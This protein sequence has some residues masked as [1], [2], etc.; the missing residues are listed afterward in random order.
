MYEI[1][2]YYEQMYEF[3]NNS[4]LYNFRFK[5]S[6]IPMW[7]Y[8]RS[9]FIRDVIDQTLYTQITQIEHIKANTKFIRKSFMSKYITKNPFFS[10]RKDILFAFWGYSELKKYDNGMVYEALIM[11]FLQMFS[12]KTSVLMHGN[13]SNEYEL[14]CSYPEWKMDD[15]FIDILNCIHNIKK[16]NI[17]NEDKKNI[18]DLVKF[19]DN[20]CPI[21]MNNCIKKKICSMLE[22][23]AHNNKFM[24][25]IC[26]LYL[27]VAKPKVVVICCGSYPGLLR[28]SLILACKN[29]SIVTAELQ[30]GLSARCHA[31]YQYGNYI[32]N[33][34]EC[35]RILPDY[36]LTFGEYWHNHV[37]IPQKCKVVGYAKPIVKDSVPVNQKILFCADLDF[38]RYLHFIDKIISHL[39]KSTE[40]YFRLHPIY[41]TKKQKEQFKK[42]LKYPNFFFA[43]DKDLSFYMK[44]CRYVIIDGST[45]C[46]EALFM[47]R[48]VFAF[49]SRQNT[50]VG[51]N[52]LPYVHLFNSSD[53]FL[54]LWNKRDMFISEYH[55]EFFNLEYKKNYIEFV[56][57]CGVKIKGVYKG[58]VR[59]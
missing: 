33:N 28:T 32:L 43:N 14:N 35:S 24:V 3:E 2:E 26:E 39:D 12:D 34:Y 40:I 19:L 18:K 37:N 51:I 58:C 54:K 48:I 15:I 27:Q 8:I 1:K 29:K 7:M 4:Q 42:Y 36:Y 23:F 6:G 10:Q 17:S 59:K 5:D 45:V 53:D 55:D 22:D 11:P 16:Q 52:K 9:L 21:K 49:E 38:D 57:E 30:H 44:E 56:K 47:G 25:R 41:S 20:S 31:N 13:I 50:K 46:Y